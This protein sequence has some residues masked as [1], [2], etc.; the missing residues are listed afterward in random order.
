MSRAEQ[1]I[2]ACLIL[3]GVI[4]IAPLIGVLGDAYLSRLYGIPIASPDLS[5]LMRH[6][7]VLFGIIGILMFAGTVRPALRTAALLAGLSSVVSFLALAAST[8]GYNR[9]VGGVVAVDAV[10]LAALLVASFLQLSRRTG[11]R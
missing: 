8:G 3:V 10:A 2:R 11:V 6:R 9:A 7:A 5:I 1:A 4:H